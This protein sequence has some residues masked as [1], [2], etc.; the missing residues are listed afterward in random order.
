MKRSMDDP[1]RTPRESTGSSIANTR[2]AGAR[3]SN[4]ALSLSVAAIAVPLAVMMLET[5]NH[6]P[7]DYGAAAA[8]IVIVTFT[9]AILG[10]GVSV[11]ALVRCRSWKAIAGLLLSIVA[12]P[13]ALY[14]GALFA[15]ATIGV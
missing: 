13:W 7:W 8:G 15:L 4:I 11:A 5:I 9:L 10:I 14:V 1:Y 6:L 3:L 12:M 2:L